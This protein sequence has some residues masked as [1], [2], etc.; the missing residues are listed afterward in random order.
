MERLSACRV[1]SMHVG[2]LSPPPLFFNYSLPKTMAGKVW[3][4]SS[5]FD[6]MSPQ[7]CKPINSTTKKFTMWFAKGKK[8]KEVA[9]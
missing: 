6:L 8:K 9:V 7:E 2:V 4:L 3:A 5:L 1:L